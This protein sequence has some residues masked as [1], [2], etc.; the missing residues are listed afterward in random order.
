MSAPGTL[1]HVKAQKQ[2]LHFPY[3]AR[4]SLMETEY[5]YPDLGD[6]TVGQNHAPVRRP[7]LHTDFADAFDAFRQRFQISSHERRQFLHRAVFPSDL[8]DFSA[9]GNLKLAGLNRAGVFRKF[10]AN[11]VIVKL[12]FFCRRLRPDRRDA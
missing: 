5:I 10:R 7:G 9:Y 1:I 6:R 12:L 2:Y 4:A 11:M 8:A 3:I